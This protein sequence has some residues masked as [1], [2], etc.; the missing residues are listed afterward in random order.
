MVIGFF[1]TN[2]KNCFS[3]LYFRKTFQVQEQ[4]YYFSWFHKCWKIW[5]FLIKILLRLRR[6]FDKE[7]HEIRKY[8]L[9]KMQLEISSKKHDPSLWFWEK[10]LSSHSLNFELWVPIIWVIIL[11]SNM[12]WMKTI[13]FYSGVYLL[14]SW[15]TLPYVNIQNFQ[16]FLKTLA[17]LQPAT[18]SACS[19][20]VIQWAL[21]NVTDNMAIMGNV[22]SQFI[23]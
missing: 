21:L 8:I 15:L 12:G 2:K 1:E 3:F 23:W 14:Y 13:V 11:S 18:Q 6:D 17:F 5:L 20:N 22:I 19:V 4:F 7:P 16:R 10:K 9:L